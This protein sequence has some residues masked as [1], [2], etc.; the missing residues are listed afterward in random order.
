MIKFGRA[1][2]LFDHIVEKANQMG[3]DMKILTEFLTFQN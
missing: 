1:K 3:D 2:E